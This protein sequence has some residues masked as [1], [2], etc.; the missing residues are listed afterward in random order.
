MVKNIML[1][2]IEANEYIP[3]EHIGES[4]I[5]NVYAITKNLNTFMN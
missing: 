3:Y 2:V 4:F 5:I 1:I